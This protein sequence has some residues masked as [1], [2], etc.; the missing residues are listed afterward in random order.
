LTRQELERRL[1]LLWRSWRRRW[2][3]ATWRARRL[4]A[5]W[6][7]SVGAVER[8][9][10]VDLAATTGPQPTRVVAIDRARRQ[11]RL[12]RCQ[13]TEATVLRSYRVGVGRRDC[14]TPTGRF[15]IGAM[16]EDPVWHVPDNPRTYGHLAGQAIPAGAPENRIAAR[17]LSV[18]GTIGIHGTAHGRLGPGASDGCVVMSVDD[19]ID[20]FSLVA[21]G[22]PVL[23]T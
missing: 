21:E 22:T 11:L 9:R 17:W 20:L 6:S 23:I 18:H 5:S 8:G 16:L 1:F 3:G 7:T 19:V 10:V 14:P 13:G 2:P 12:Y 4:W 15:A